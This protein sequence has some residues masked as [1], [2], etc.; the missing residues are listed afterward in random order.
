ME[1][2]VAYYRVSTKQQGKSGLGLA[3]QREIIGKF[4]GNDKALIEEY[5]E[6]ESGRKDKREILWTAIAHAKREKAKLLIA[7]LD[8]FSRRVS[9]IANLMEEGIGLTV[10]EMPTATDFQLHIFAALAQEERRLISERTKAALQQAKKRGVEL[11]KNG[12]ILA[13]QNKQRAE[14]FRANLLQHVPDANLLNYSEIV[15]RLDKQGF[16]TPKGRKFTIR[17]ACRYFGRSIL[18]LRDG[19]GRVTDIING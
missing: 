4:I 12:A 14:E 3:A 18:G 17:S 13:L 11:G 9:F 5:E 8:R 15:C 6:V 2:Y 16:L 1:K 10:A 19:K 7:R